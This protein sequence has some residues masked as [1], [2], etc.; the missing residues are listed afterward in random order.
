MIRMKDALPDMPELCAEPDLVEKIRYGQKLTAND[1]IG[2]N[3]IQRTRKA[4][5]YLKIVDQEEEL[6]AIME[7]NKIGEAKYWAF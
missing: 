5:D 6:M 4:G 7:Q 3:G 1:L 2:S